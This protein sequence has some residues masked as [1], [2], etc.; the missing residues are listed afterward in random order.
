[1]NDP[2][3]SVAYYDHSQLADEI[4]VWEP[5]CVFRSLFSLIE[6]LNSLA[7]AD[8]AYTLGRLCR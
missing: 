4:E 5:T 8:Q 7:S 6:S 2:K 3:G 1:M